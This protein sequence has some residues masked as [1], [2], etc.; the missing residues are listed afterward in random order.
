MP[1]KPPKP[2]RVNPPQPRA[3][4]DP[5]R[6]V[7]E[8]AATCKPEILTKEAEP[9][10]PVWR[11]AVHAR[12]KV[13]APPIIVRARL[14]FEA[15]QEALSVYTSLGYFLDPEDVILRRQ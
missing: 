10:L 9:E 13:D 12:A 3:T 15:R 1:R 6:S 14:W 7:V 4:V 2:R 8:Y 11:A 5:C